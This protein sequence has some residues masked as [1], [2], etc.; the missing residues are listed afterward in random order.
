MI[1]AIRS[2][3]A[4]TLIGT[5]YCKTGM[6]GEGPT[7]AKALVKGCTKFEEVRGVPPGD[8]IGASSDG[9]WPGSPALGLRHKAPRPCCQGGGGARHSSAAAGCRLAGAMQRGP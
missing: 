8:D 6:P 3:A 5:D 9:A 1:P 2:S 7:T 4:A